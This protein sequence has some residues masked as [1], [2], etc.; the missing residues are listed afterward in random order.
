[1][2]RNITLEAASDVKSFNYCSQLINMHGFNWI[3][4]VSDLTN[5]MAHTLT[6]ASLVKQ[7]ADEATSLEELREKANNLKVEIERLQN[8][9]WDF[10]ENEDRIKKEKW[11]QEQEKW[12][13]ENPEFLNTKRD[14]LVSDFLDRPVDR[15]VDELIEED[16]HES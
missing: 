6:S 9:V 7:F 15:P 3:R 10:K 4:D 13:L 1:M 16:L 12:E 14:E 2:S 11:K 5:A 8:Y